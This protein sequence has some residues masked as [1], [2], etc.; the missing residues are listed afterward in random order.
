ME[1]DNIIFFFL[2]VKVSYSREKREGI[3]N[4]SKNGTLTRHRGVKKD[5]YRK[6]G[7]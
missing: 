4:E 3:L 1:E 6:N 5:F 7:Y 2:S